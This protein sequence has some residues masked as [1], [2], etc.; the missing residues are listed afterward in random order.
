MR[1]LSIFFLLSLFQVQANAQN[2]KTVNTPDTTYFRGG[3]HRSDYFTNQ[4]SDILKMTFTDSSSASGGDSTFYFYNAIRGTGIGQ[5]LDT[6]AP[7][8]LGSKFI[9]K[10]NGTEYYF[11][12]I[13]D[14]ITINT[15][16]QQ[17]DTWTLA[18]DNTNLTFEATVISTG[19][20]T[21]EGVPD[22]F[23]R[24]TIQAYQ[25]GNAIANPYNGKILEWSKDH[26]W[27]T[28]LDLYRFPNQINGWE[29]FGVLTDSTQLTRLDNGFAHLDMNYIDLLWKYTPG[30]EWIHHDEQGM[31]MYG[32]VPYDGALK[33]IIH[34]SVISSSL[35]NSNS[36]EVNFM[37]KKYTVN[38]WSFDITNNHFDSTA[39]SVTIFHTDTI[40]LITPES[41]ADNIH[42]E[43]LQPGL[44]IP[45]INITPE[46]HTRYFTDTLCG[47]PTLRSYFL[48]GYYVHY[49]NNCW[50]FDYG[51]S[52]GSTSSD[53]RLYGFGPISYLYAT[54]GLVLMY[55]SLDYYQKQYYSYLKLPNC[56][57]GIKIDVIALDAQD[58]VK[59]KPVINVYPNPAKGSICFQSSYIDPE[60][61]VRLTDMT[62]KLLLQQQGLQHNNLIDTKAIA[63]G[64]YLI[65]VVT[66]R[67]STTIKVMIQ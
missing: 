60:A 14:T 45:D 44:Q 67:G 53:T 33:T 46:M 59:A 37:T 52:G 30:N 18:K 35:L 17:G 27:L 2:W 19:L 34:D 49:S 40:S 63:S 62:G 66:A 32:S 28:T 56:T 47:R 50:V 11:N 54:S 29:E 21:V 6:I 10:A 48:N 5:C 7:T 58:L 25:N 39:S 23:K 42:R 1:P 16:V 24:L 31:A 15:Q 4:Y 13:S 22:S 12:S 55:G 65:H 8:W 38:N 3:L 9:H 41:I 61:S 26:G 20:T 43:L 36:I 64:M 57:S 51:I